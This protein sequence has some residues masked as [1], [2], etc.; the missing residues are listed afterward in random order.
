VRESPALCSS[1]TCGVWLPGQH[2]GEGES[3][4]TFGCSMHCPRE[5]GA[6]QTAGWIG[7]EAGGWGGDSTSMRWW[8]PSRWWVTH[9]AVSNMA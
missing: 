4:T 7:G 8:L 9:D 2:D 6:V 5:L 3:T 1:L